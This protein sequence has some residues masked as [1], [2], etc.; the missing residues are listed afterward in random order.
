M[1]QF[2]KSIVENALSGNAPLKET[3]I[4]IQV[5]GRSP[6]YDPSADPIVRVE[7]R[8]LRQKLRHYYEGEGAGDPFLISLPTGGYAPEFEFRTLPVPEPAVVLPTPAADPA[9]AKPPQR[10]F[11]YLWAAIALCGLAAL[12]TWIVR[13]RVS[14][15]PTTAAKPSGLAVSIAVL[16]L[17]NLSGDPAQE[18]LADGMTDELIGSLAQISSLRVISRTSAMQY[19]GVTKPVREIAKELGVDDVVEGS[20]ARSGQQVRITAQ[21]IEANADRHLWSQDY[22]RQIGDLFQIESEVAQAIARQIRVQLSIAEEARLQRQTEVAP[23]VWDAYLKGR[24]FW[25]RR[26]EP[27]L[28]KA[29]AYYREAVDKAPWYATAWAGLADCWLV[30]GETWIKGDEAKM[31]SHAQEAVDK[32]LALDDLLGEAHAS[33]AALEANR[34]LWSS[35]EADYRRALEL[36]PGDATAHQWYAEGLATQGRMEE[37]VAEIH[38]ARELDPLSLT[39]NVQVGYILFMARRYDEAIAQLRSASDMDPYFWMAHAVLGHAYLMKRMYQDAVRELRTAADL[40]NQGYGQVVWLAHAWA[41]AGNDREARRLRTELEPADAQ[42]Q[43]DPVPMAML[44]LA[45][46]ERGRAKKRL[47]SAC[48]GKIPPKFGPSP[49]LDFL[50]ADPQMKAAMAECTSRQ[51]P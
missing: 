21:L 24:Y 20:V 29:I 31:Y 43:V 7:A 22:R 14:R 50:R 38:R 17:A 6:D 25:N 47:E 2:L 33:R 44:H 8:R 4:G 32:A 10:R 37:A 49:V 5:F 34:G 16:P 9:P 23:D 28:R 13:A 15:L 11:G 18:Y 3:L 30:L 41:V 26:T 51:R 48:G 1:C 19:K 35:A 36:S 46:G 45:L 42:G 39:V 27:D 40:T 12:S